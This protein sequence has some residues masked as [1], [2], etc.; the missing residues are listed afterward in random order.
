MDL[1][2]IISIAGMSGLY[3]VAA[4]T[5]NGFIVE[6]I[7]EKKKL[8]VYSSQK[9]SSL[10]DISIYCKSGDSPLKDIL[11]KI[12]DKH[13]GG[14][15][16][17]HK[18]NDAELKKYFAEAIPDYDEE[19]VYVSDIKKVIN[20]YNI[21][22]KNDLLKSKA[23]EAPVEGEDKPKLKLATDEKHKASPKI[24]PKD[25]SAKPVKTNAPKVKTQTVRKTG[26]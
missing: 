9:I 5:K 19:R 26:A 16:I 4:Q 24:V 14:Q 11:Q 17:D 21:L 3:K 13:Q 15:A 23:D 1:S 2:G 18:S 22:Q 7:V 12:Y 10:E 25:A 8:P 20:W 6:S